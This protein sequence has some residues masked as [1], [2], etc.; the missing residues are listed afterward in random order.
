MFHPLSSLN[1][2]IDIDS[3]E[4]ST[5][6]KLI[7]S[8]G[9]RNKLTCNIIAHVGAEINYTWIS[10]LDN[11]TAATARTISLLRHGSADLNGTEEN[12]TCEG[13]VE[14]LSEYQFVSSM[15]Y[16]MLS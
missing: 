10:S 7:L 1:T 2:V 6:H 12:I 16:K 14:G 3:D 4:N 13:K 9:I 5:H 8:T 15:I 11:E